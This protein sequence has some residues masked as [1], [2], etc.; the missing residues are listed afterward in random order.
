M[1][2]IFLTAAAAIAIAAPG[3]AAAQ[4]GYV[5][6][7]YTSV[8]VDGAGDDDA[9]GASG[10]VELGQHFAVDGGFSSNDDD[11]G[12]GATGHV[13]MNDS[14]HLLGVFAGVSDSDIATVWQ[15]GVEGQAYLG[16][17]T[18]AGALGYG[19]E[20]DLDVSA[21]GVNGEARFFVNPN[22]RLEGGLGYFNVDTP[23]GD[24]DALQFGVGGE[25]Q[26]AAAPI[27][28]GLGYT[29]TSL[30]ETDIEI[31]A[32]SATARWNFGGG[33]LA[34]RDR[35]GAALAGLSGIGAALGL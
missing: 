17:V 34:D 15:G 4:T 20:D 14:S 35:T 26:L 6:M 8:D 10:A 25:Y 29:R 30:D 18:F 32:I 5:G 28:L 11:T 21:L 33:T 13:Y 22:F 31:D 2:K 1:R 19:R 23:I 16:N 9:W 3:V 24:D 12:F 7:D 27:S